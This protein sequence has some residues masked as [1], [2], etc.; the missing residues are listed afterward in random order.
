MILHYVKNT[1][2]YFSISVR[3]ASNVSAFFHYRHVAM[4]PLALVSY[5]LMQRL[6]KGVNPGGES[7]GYGVYTFSTHLQITLQEVVIIYAPG[8]SVGAFLGTYIFSTIG[9]FHDFNSYK[10]EG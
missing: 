3:S 5:I 10:C 8:S 9:H 6:R 1:S 7:L 4:N 2:V